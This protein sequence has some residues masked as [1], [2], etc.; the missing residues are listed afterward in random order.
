[1]NIKF[2]FFFVL[3]LVYN[4]SLISQISSYIHID[5]FGYTISADKVAVLSNPI[6]GYNSN[7]SYTPG[8]SIEVIDAFTQAIVFQASPSIWGGGSEDTL[9]GD[10]GWWFDFSSLQTAGTYYIFDPT[11]NEKSG[12]FSIN[13]NPY[14][15]V[16]KASFNS[17]LLVNQPMHRH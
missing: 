8:S 13:S 3:C 11:N 16:L 9:S 5:Q 17:F 10:E 14:H 12:L 4:T 15:D 2:K 6:T 1:M 7:L